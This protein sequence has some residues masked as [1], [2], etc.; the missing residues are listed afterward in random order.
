M[1]KMAKYKIFI[2][3]D[4]PMIIKGLQTLVPWEEIHCEI[5][6]TAK[7][8]VEGLEA[9]IA[10]KPDIVIS[11]IRMPRLNGLEMIEQL[12][13]EAKETKFIVLT[14][15]REFDYAQKAVGLGVVK[16]LLKPTNI[17]DIK[18]AV[19]EAMLQLED[20]HSKEEDIQR[21]RNKLEETM[22]IYN[23]T[24]HIHL[25]ESSQEASK[26]QEESESRMK[27][28]AVQAIN[29]MKEN[30]SHKLD[31][32]EVADY[33]FI[34]TWYLCKILKQELD[35]SFVQL[36]NEIRIQE[37]KRLLVETQY[38]VYEIGDKVGYADTPYFTKTFK[39]YTGVTP[40]QYRNTYYT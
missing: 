39:K 6:G 7:N 38:K 35:N 9:I 19:I 28:L 17:E 27:Y 15:Y 12:K 14:S 40:N 23:E 30:Y 13:A 31:L 36:L 24:A 34:S 32:Q 37:A 26:E 16:Y 25:E 5:C 22:N 1:E 18:S 21:L 10:K 2:I 33:L 8:G 11:D 29:Y 20:E 3:D 4:E